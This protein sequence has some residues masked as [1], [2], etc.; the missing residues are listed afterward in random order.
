MNGIA[1]LSRFYPTY[2]AHY[3]ALIF[4]IIKQV[5]FVK[6]KFYKITVI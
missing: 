4:I 6:K 3:Y 1:N 5:I 2:S